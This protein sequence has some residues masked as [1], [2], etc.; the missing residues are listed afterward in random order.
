MPNIVLVR[1][2]EYQAKTPVRWF[3]AQ[4][5]K[6]KLIQIDDVYDMPEEAS[7]DQATLLGWGARALLGIPVSADNK[8]AGCCVFNSAEQRAW[9]QETIQEL[10]LLGDAITAACYRHRA[11]AEILR[12]EQDL[13]QSQQVGRTYRGG[14][15]RSGNLA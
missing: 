5:L 9:D 15:R 12:S 8:I 13:A 1:S 14:K 6:G 7:A 11:T 2:P 10:G 3:A 4:V